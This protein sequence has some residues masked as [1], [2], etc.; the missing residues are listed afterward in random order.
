LPETAESLYG[1]V[2]AQKSG[3]HGCRRHSHFLLLTTIACIEIDAVNAVR[4]FI[5]TVEGKLV[6]DVQ[7]DEH[8]NRQPRTQSADIQQRKNA[9]FGQVA[10]G[11]GEM[12][13]QHGVVVQPNPSSV[14]LL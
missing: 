6:A 9:V 7:S 10:Q 13:F 4:F 8:G 1:R 14:F 12:I 11:D 2:I 3:P 5:K